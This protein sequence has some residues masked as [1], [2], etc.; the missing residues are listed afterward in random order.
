MTKAERERAIA[1]E[2]TMACAVAGV[3]QRDLARKL[4]VSQTSICRLLNGSSTLRMDVADAIA[5][6]C[7][8]RLVLRVAP[9]NGLSLRDSG[10]LGVAQVI[11]RAAA[12]PW[13][14]RLEVPVGTGGDR[15]AIDLVL[16]QPSEIVAIEIERWLRDLQAQLRAGQLK[17][18]ELSER[19]GMTVRFILAL[20]D[21]AAMR[22]I[23]APYEELIASALP[24]S[25]R[26]AWARIRSGQP[27]GGDALLWV[28]A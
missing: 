26:T 4:S 2:L 12:P 15:R 18:S 24:V 3:T 27:I 9:G 7:G 13:L 25:S 23:V 19:M 8:H 5:R 22:R 10:Q 14:T 28:R 16:M 21:T 20:P 6:A 1:R 17:R 11:E